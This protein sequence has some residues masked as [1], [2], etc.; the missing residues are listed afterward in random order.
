M[1]W[2]NFLSELV[3]VLSIFC[4]SAIVWSMF[5][6]YLDSDIVLSENVLNLLFLCKKYGRWNPLNLSKLADLIIMHKKQKVLDWLKLRKYN[7]NFTCWFVDFSH[8]Y[9]N[10]LLQLLLC[11]RSKIKNKWLILSVR[12]ILQLSLETKNWKFL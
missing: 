2:V 5:W 10:L 4:D 6:I 7:C 3:I 8:I 9:T 12:S 11:C 1:F